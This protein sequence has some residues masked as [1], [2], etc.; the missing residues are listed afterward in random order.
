LP[1][2]F[3]FAG[4]RAAGFFFAALVRFA[5][6]GYALNPRLYPKS[7]RRNRGLRKIQA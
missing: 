7:C 5:A 1:A 3:F 6:A 4:L 2:A